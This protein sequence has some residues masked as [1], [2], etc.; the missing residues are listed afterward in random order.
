[1]TITVHQPASSFT[2]NTS[3][4]I[5]SFYVIYCHELKRRV[6]ATCIDS[7]EDGKPKR[8][9]IQRSM[10]HG[11]DVVMPGSYDILEKDPEWED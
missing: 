11:G 9:R 6:L 8:M 1:M 2:I 3:N 5:G 7:T 10:F 4:C